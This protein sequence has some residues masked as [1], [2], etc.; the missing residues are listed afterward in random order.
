MWKF[1]IDYTRVQ[2]IFSPPSTPLGRMGKDSIKKKLILFGGTSVSNPQT[3]V[4][5]NDIWYYDAQSGTTKWV[6]EV[7]SPNSPPMTARMDHACA[8]NTQTGVMNVH[9][10]IDTNSAY[11]TYLWHYDF[12]SKMWVS[13]SNGINQAQLAGHSMLY[14]SSSNFIFIFFG[15]L[16][17]STCSNDVYQ[18]SLQANT[19][20]ALNVASKPPSCR[21]YF[22]GSFSPQTNE[23]FVFGGKTNSGILLSIID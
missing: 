13:V 17:S 7:P 21:S 8:F 14:L 10:G 18:Y 9:G 22:V 2:L 11:M 1:K 23:Y 19:W 12:S 5:L 4:R 6:Q 20:T 3:T 15:A 16:S